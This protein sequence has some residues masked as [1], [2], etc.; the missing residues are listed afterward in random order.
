MILSYYSSP[1][2]PIYKILI[3]VNVMILVLS[4]TRFP[5]SKA[6]EVGKRYLE[7][8]KEFPPDKSIAKDILRLGTRIIGDAKELTLK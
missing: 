7:V 8:S 1:L 5:I 2:N 3:E 6:K 4:T